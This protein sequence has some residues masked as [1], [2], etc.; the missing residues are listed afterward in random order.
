MRGRTSA[1]RRFGQGGEAEESSI[2]RGAQQACRRCTVGRNGEGEVSMQLFSTILQINEKLTREAFVRLVIDWNQHSPH[3]ENIIPGIE[4]DGTYSAR[5]GDENLWLE[6]LEYPKEDIVA[7]RYEKREPGG[8]V[9]DTDYVMNFATRQM[10]IR[11]DRSFLAEALD[12]DQR[13]STP[14]FI[15]LL[16]D[17]GYLVDDGALPISRKPYEI[18]TD[19]VDLLAGVVN[20]ES[21]FRLP[22]IYI[23]KTERDENP[24]D[25]NLLAYKLKGAAHVLV[26]KGNWSN[27]SIQAACH[28]KNEYYGAV[29][30]YFP[31]AAISHKRLLDRSNSHL[32]E[33][34]MQAVMLYQNS[35]IVDPL[36]TWPGVRGA[37][38]SDRYEEQ[39]RARAAAE[40]EREQ[41]RE[42]AQML[43]LFE[44]END[45]LAAQN[46]TLEEQI[47]ELRAAN[48]SLEA[49]NRGLRARLASTSSVPVLT[50]GNEEDLFPG[51]IRDL[52]LSVLQKELENMD[53]ACRR[54]DV[55]RDL[56]EANHYE[57]IT[58]Q[59]AAEVKRLVSAYDGMDGRMKS[60]LK[61]LGLY[62][63]SDKNHYKFSY[64]GDSRYAVV[65]AK[66][67][68][69]KAREGKNNAQVIIK[70]ML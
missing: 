70:R 50:F 11:L 47:R 36:Y 49:E 58:E 54:A 59:R 64:Y 63:E 61:D 1:R 66:T 48:A 14:Y 22:V 5:L 33:E 57:R 29:G 56:L 20:G 9:W 17:E 15:K 45:A 28:S 4:W 39:K 16:I 18:D 37:I 41:A 30:I 7:V 6:I 26:Q 55:F 19:N 31:T 21:S 44:D 13:F 35:L 62:L 32:L 68:S 65:F 53:P 24:V 67:P 2:D 69:D 51:E 25:V 34:T 46:E 40:R 43:P 12:V 3:P 10:G 52:V 38:L 8:A 27:P 60:T 23:S 42:D